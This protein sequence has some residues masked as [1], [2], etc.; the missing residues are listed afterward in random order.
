MNLHLI[1]NPTFYALAVPAVVLTGIAKAGF[2]GALG[3]FA[4]PLM[5]AV[6]APGDAAGIMLPLLC[7][8]DISGLRPF[9]FR[10]DKASVR[11]L[12]PAGI[13]GV[14]LGALLYPWMSE[15]L[16]RV[17]IGLI[18][19]LFVLHGWLFAPRRATVSGTPGAVSGLSCGA[20]GGFT[21][22]LA[23]AGGPPL[24]V[25]LLPQGFDRT[26]FV[27]TMNLYFLVINWTK[28]VPYTFEGQFSGRNLG[29]SLLLAPLV[30]VGVWLGLRLHARIN[31][32][33]F[34]RIAR[35]ALLVT[36]IQLI[37]QGLS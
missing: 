26:R 32:V 31:E 24:L 22:F 34:Y 2:G 8:T 33:W 13:A 12:I 20:L 17:L 3:G 36:G 1:T 35:L 28:L 25:H 18:S 6:I 29:T 14:A 30:P 4:V 9:L 19:V 16:V 5:S 21:S 23:H 10:W 27:A 11:L 15:A 37:V 7:F